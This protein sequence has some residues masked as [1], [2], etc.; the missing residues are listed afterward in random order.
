MVFKSDT[1]ILKFL[2]FLFEFIFNIEVVILQFFLEVG[3]LVEQIVELVHLE[4]KVLFGD[5]E[6]SDLFLMT[7][8]LVVES[9]LLLFEDRL[10]GSQLIAVGLDVHVVGLLLDEIGLVSNPLLL[11][12]DDLV[13]KLLGLLKNVVLLSLHRTRVLVDTSIFELSPDSVELIDSQ[14]SLIDLVVSLL[15]VLLEL[16][17]FVLLLLELGDQVVQLFLEELVLLNTVEVIDSDSGDLI[18]E[19]LD[20]DLLLSDVLVSSL[21]LLQEIG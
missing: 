17:N 21:G 4:I 7:L 19:V 20:F 16:L 8:D 9:H 5:L 6:H 15:V 10:S 12:V 1:F 13:L 11:N 2:Q 3:V 18:A 14:L